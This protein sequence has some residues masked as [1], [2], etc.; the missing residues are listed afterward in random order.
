MHCLYTHTHTHA[1][2]GLSKSPFLKCHTRPHTGSPTSVLPIIAGSQKGPN[3]EWEHSGL[4]GSLVCTGSLPCS[5]GS[6]QTTSLPTSG[7]PPYPGTCSLRSQ[8]LL[9]TQLRLLTAFHRVQKIR[10]IQVRG[11]YT[12]HSCNKFILC[13]TAGHCGS[14]GAQNPGRRTRTQQRQLSLTEA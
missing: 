4:E 7:C 10:E 9:L 1:L 6:T 11:G 2:S 8:K 3:D 12:A 14:Q 13:Q 5:Q